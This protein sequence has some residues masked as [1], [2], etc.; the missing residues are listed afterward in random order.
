MATWE[1]AGHDRAWGRK[2]GDPRVVHV[3]PPESFGRE[4]EPGFLLRLSGA[5]GPEPVPA[6]L[7]WTSV[8]GRLEATST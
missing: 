4:T 1:R 2:S 3:V 5:T 7:G 6:A 8:V